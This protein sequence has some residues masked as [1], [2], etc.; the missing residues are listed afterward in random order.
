[1]IGHER[2]WRYSFLG[3][4]V[5]VLPLLIAGQ[6]VRIQVDPEQ[7]RK[8]EAF[9]EAWAKEPHLINPAR[10]QIHDR[11]GNLLAGN[12]TVYEVGAELRDVKNPQTIALTLK[13]VL[14]ADYAEVFALASIESSDKA[15]YAVLVDNVPQDRIDDL[16]FVIRQMKGAYGENQEKGAPSLEGLVYKPHLGR[17]Y[18]ENTL[19]SNVLGFVS[20]EGQG[21]FGV[22]E[23]FNDMLAGKPKIVMVPKDP[24]LAR[25]R[26]EIPAGASLVLTLDRAIQRS[27]ERIID[28]AIA[29][30]G[31][32]S[33]T[34]VVM[35]PRTGEILAVATTPRLNL[36][37]FWRYSDLFPEGLLSI[38]P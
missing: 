17:I 7:G 1:M 18:P 34:L 2:N 25:E 38:A 20:R 5:F 4:L 9:S 26:P 24:N 33:G 10:G 36:N 15:V 37:E 27:M 14:D 6:M 35:D 21:Y 11:W 16:E 23:R 19:A 8:F 30:T 12:R 32:A 3:I 28:A 29:E 13:T 31:A 22:E